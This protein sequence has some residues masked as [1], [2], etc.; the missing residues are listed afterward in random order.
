L[1]EEIKLK[2]QQVTNLQNE[3]KL[4]QQETL[5]LR[6]AEKQRDF[7]FNELKNQETLLLAKITQLNQIVD[8]K[9]LEIR[10]LIN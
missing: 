3:K 9:N 2:N 10:N 6:E 5:K 7:Q 4:S 1:S 8:A